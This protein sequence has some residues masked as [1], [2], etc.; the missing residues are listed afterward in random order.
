MGKIICWLQAIHYSIPQI[1]KGSYP[2]DGHPYYETYRNDDV[3][4]LKCMRCNHY[5]IGYF[6]GGEAE[7][8]VLNTKEI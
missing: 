5:S 1:L 4:I 8:P 2:I 6:N 3:Q 7:P